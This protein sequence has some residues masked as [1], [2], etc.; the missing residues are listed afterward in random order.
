MKILGT[1]LPLVPGAQGYVPGACRGVAILLWSADP[2]VPERL[3][4]PFFHAAAAAALEVEVELYF[5]AAS[6]RLLAPGVADGLRSSEH[7]DSTVGEAMRLAHQ[8]GARLYACADALKAQGLHLEALIAIC[9][10]LGGSVQFMA[11]TIDPAWR[12]L[13]Y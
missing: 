5:S 9:S 8:H 12:T 7:S 11:R 10:G 6:V 3:S 4:T 1:E 13:V 2:Q